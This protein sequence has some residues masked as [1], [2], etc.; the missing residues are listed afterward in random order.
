MIL[1]EW[2]APEGD[3]GQSCVHLFACILSTSSSSVSIFSVCC[4]SIVSISMPITNLIQSGEC[5]QYS[6]RVS[7]V[8]CTWLAISHIL[9]SFV[10]RNRWCC[11]LLV[12][13]LKMNTALEYSTRVVQEGGRRCKKSTLNGLVHLTPLRIPLMN[14][15]FT[16]MKICPVSAFPRPNSW[17]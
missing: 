15:P 2:D 7:T 5:T 10:D 14:P 1:C 13:S 4:Y 11:Q 8:Q 3:P 9:T 17:T 6:T 12:G 16:F